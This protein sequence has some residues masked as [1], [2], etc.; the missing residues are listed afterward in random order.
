MHGSLQNV[1]SLIPNFL[2]SRPPCLNRPTTLSETC[3]RCLVSAICTLHEVTHISAKFINF[4]F[5]TL[6]S[7]H[8]R[9]NFL[10][11]HF[12]GERRRAQGGCKVRVTHERRSAKK[13]LARDSY[14]A[15]ALRSPPFAS[16]T[17]KLRL[18]C[19]LDSAK[20][21]LLTR[22]ELSDQH[23]SQFSRF[24][25]AIVLHEVNSGCVLMGS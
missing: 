9:R 5:R 21:Y 3:R 1:F 18:F 11:L 6:P 17:K 19:R 2:R 14:F 23:K 4:Q 15:V 22:Q 12:L 16:R 13:W 24:G 8:D 25:Q 7:L 20:L 10:S